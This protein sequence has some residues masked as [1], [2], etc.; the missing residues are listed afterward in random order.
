MHSKDHQIWPQNLPL[1]SPRKT[2]PRVPTIV[3]SHS[4]DV[5]QGEESAYGFSDDLLLLSIW[6]SPLIC[7][8]YLLL[9]NKLSHEI[10]ASNIEH[11][12]SYS[13][14]G[15]EIPEQFSWVVL[16]QD[17]MRF[18]SRC[19]LGCRVSDS[20][21]RRHLQAHSHGLQ[22]KSSVTHHVGLSTGLL[23]CPHNMAGGFPEQMIQESESVQR[24]SL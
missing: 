9:C 23:E 16:A 21:W 24:P 3:G 13:F 11:V 14:Y 5:C 8:S 15:S 12:L 22:L 10:V 6:P 4:K 7:I 19:Q 1:S 18:Q 17:L 2:F 20:G